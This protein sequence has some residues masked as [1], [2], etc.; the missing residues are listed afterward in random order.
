MAIQQNQVILGGEVQKVDYNK[1]RGLCRIHL[2]VPT[3]NENDEKGK[4]KPP[5]TVSVDVVEPKAALASTAKAGDFF[6]CKAF[7]IKLKVA[8]DHEVKAIADAKKINFDELM[9]KKKNKDRDAAIKFN[10]LAKEAKKYDTAW[11]QAD[12]DRPI[13]IIPDGGKYAKAALNE[14]SFQG[15]VMRMSDLIEAGKTKMLFVTLVFNPPGKKDESDEDRKKNAVFLDVATFGGTAE[16]FV[17]PYLSDGDTFLATG[18]MELRKEKWTVN[19]NDWYAL[20][21]RPSFFQGVQFET[22]AK[23]GG[24]KKPSGPNTDVYKDGPGGDDDLPF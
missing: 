7:I 20:T 8:P 16:K 13:V 14:A 4:D 17:K 3:A 24:G 10:E 12:N 23:G 22:P 15:R 21:L 19:G 1:Q 2:L 5:I 11:M 18:Q 6:S 9:T